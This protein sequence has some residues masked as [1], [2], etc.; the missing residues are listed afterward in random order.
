MP[1]ELPAFATF[2]A[3]PCS[4][5]RQDALGEGHVMQFTG[6]TIRQKIAL[7]VLCAR[8]SVVSPPLLQTETIL[9][10]IRDCWAIAD[11]F[12]R[13]EFDEAQRNAPPEP[14]VPPSVIIPTGGG[15]RP[16]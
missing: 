11:A 8:L 13:H 5:H 12:I 7:D 3:F 6:M 14:P 1:T 16:Q 9:S 15:P 4:I 2:P 10:L